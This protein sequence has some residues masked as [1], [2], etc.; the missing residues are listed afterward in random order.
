[1]IIKMLK[2]KSVG[3]REHAEGVEYELE[4][5]VAEAWIKE[6]V[7]EAVVEV[8]TKRRGIGPKIFSF[9]RPVDHR[10]LQLL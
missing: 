1:M 8:A 5:Q 9:A 6:G 2:N 7:A 4:D 3:A 10:D